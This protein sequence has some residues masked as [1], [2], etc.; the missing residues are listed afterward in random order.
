MSDENTSTAVAVTDLG[1]HRQKAN[2][3][4][5]VA[6]GTPRA[7]VPV[8]FE[9]AWRI[10]KAVCS[11]GM[12]PKTLDSAEKCMVAILH[13]LEVGLTPMAALQS[14]AVINGRPTIWGDGAIG[15][16]RASGKLEWMQEKLVGEGDTLKA[17]CTVKRKGEPEPV[18]GEFST[19]DA[20]KAG[21]WGKA[22]PWQTYP[23]RMLQMRARWPLRDVFAD[24][25]KGLSLQEEVED[26]VAAPAHVE[27]TAKPALAPPPPDEI[28]PE[29]EPAK[30]VTAS[31][32]SA[33]A[34]GV[35]GGDGIP[36]F[37][38][39]RPK[40]SPVTDDERDWLATLG[41]ALAECHDLD[42]LDAEWDSIAK[43]ATDS[44]SGEAW[45]Q[46]VAIFKDHVDRV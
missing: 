9:G 7:I 23:R 35:V 24:V 17:I 13:G 27:Q 30:T 29:P 6:G 16:I 20:K 21:L 15:L 12:A 36:P 8:D 25:L 45:S 46:A 11:A 2:P 42:S 1:Q 39:R 10:A 43:P 44:V 26:M 40:R 41:E 18:V 38:D 28:E 19:A 4:A 5:L 32:A 37:L 31:I 3:V 22:G 33:K 34:E 14:I